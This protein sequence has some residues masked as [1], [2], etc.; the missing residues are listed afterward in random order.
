MNP[1]TAILGTTT[2]AGRTQV[3]VHA[4]RGYKRPIEASH[5][6][7]MNGPVEVTYKGAQIN[8]LVKVEAK[9]LKETGMVEL[10]SG[11]VEGEDGRQ[12]THWVGSKAGS[13][14]ITVSSR[15]W[16]AMYF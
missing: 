6:S 10:R 13:D 7:A 4:N 3:V 9:E 1:E 16:V 11:E 14:R 12:W 8:G 5:I 2:G 15:G